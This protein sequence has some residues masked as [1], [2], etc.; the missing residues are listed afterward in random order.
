[1]RELMNAEYEEEL[2]EAILPVFKVE[3]TL[4]MRV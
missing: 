3:V 1:M 2:I 4:K